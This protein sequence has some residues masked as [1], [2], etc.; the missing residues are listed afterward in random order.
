MYEIFSWLA[1]CLILGAALRATQAALSPEVIKKETYK[2]HIVA[3]LTYAAVV[4]AVSIVA[5]LSYAAVVALM[6]R[7]S[8]PRLVERPLYQ[9]SSASIPTV[10]PMPTPMAE[11]TVVAPRATLPDV[12]DIR[13]RMMDAVT[14][15]PT[16]AIVPVITRS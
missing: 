1:A 3:A 4:G 9:R 6:G 11:A 14:N 5:A 10:E 8:L 13:R 7:P 2:Q 12:S 16:P 15:R